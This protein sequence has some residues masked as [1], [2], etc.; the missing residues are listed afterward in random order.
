MLKALENHLE[1]PV[2]P[3]EMVATASQLFTGYLVI[4]GVSCYFVCARF[5]DWGVH[6]S[7]AAAEAKGLL[8]TRSFAEFGYEVRTLVRGQLYRFG[9]L[10]ESTAKRL[11]QAIAAVGGEA[12]EVRAERHPVHSRP[13]LT[14][15]DTLSARPSYTMSEPEGEGASKP[16]PP[17]NRR[18]PPPPPALTSE[19][20][21]AI[22]SPF[23][24]FTSTSPGLSFPSRDKPKP[25]AF[26]RDDDDDDDDDDFGGHD[27]NHEICDDDFDFDD[28]DDDDDGGGD[29]E[30]RASFEALLAGMDV[31]AEE[32]KAAKP[33]A[34]A[35]AVR[36]F[37]RGIAAAFL[38][39]F[40]S[41]M[42]GEIV[43][44][45]ELQEI[46]TDPEIGPYAWSALS[47]T[48]VAVPGGLVCLSFGR[49]LTLLFSG[50]FA[51][52]VAFGLFTVVGEPWILTIAGWFILSW[53]YMS[54][55][56]AP[57]SLLKAGAV[58]GAM[59]VLG[60]SLAGDMGTGGAF[61]V[62][63]FWLIHGFWEKI[64]LTGAAKAE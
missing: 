60:T 55:R 64:D 42:A 17:P 54:V 50:V 13:P 32:A 25:F 5:G 48:L 33:D 49:T 21:V 37:V 36:P 19:P 35:V 22:S 44:T 2:R 11:A 34:G 39:V 23:T 8:A 26:P 63:T 12:A 27:E 45:V 29:S 14:F 38:F 31:Q 52:A 61:E 3:R 41:E 62:G 18:P 57:S 51:G 20:S 6:S 15:S 30:D 4:E 46:L 40:I 28:D 43:D 7:F 1:R 47:W 58:A 10:D 56:E 24:S 59:A 53:A 16:P 9:D